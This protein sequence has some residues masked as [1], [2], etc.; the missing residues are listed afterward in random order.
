MS[1]RAYFE[2]R[3]PCGSRLLTSLLCVFAVEQRRHRTESAR[4][5]S[6]LDIVAWM[7]GNDPLGV[8]LPISDAGSGAIPAL[9]TSFEGLTGGQETFVAA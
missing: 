2:G 8:G 3:T 7:R 6:M 4:A 9:F 5:A 1:L